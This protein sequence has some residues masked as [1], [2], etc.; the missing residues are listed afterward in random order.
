[1]T[2]KKTYDGHYFDG[3]DAY[4]ILK[5]ENG[6]S[7]MKKIKKKNLRRKVKNDLVFSRPDCRNMG[8][9]EI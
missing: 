9:L 4:D 1:M 5:D 7:S 2:K 6:K 8:W 3:K